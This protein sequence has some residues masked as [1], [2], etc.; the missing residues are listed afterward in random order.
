V[1]LKL[2]GSTSGSVELDV[3]AVVGGDVSLELP[4]GGTVD[5]LERAGNILQ[6]VSASTSTPVVNATNAYVDT[7]L[8]ATIT[9]TSASSKVLVLITQQYYHTR[10]DNKQGIGIRI[11]RDATLIY[12]PI[13]NATGPL[14]DYLQLNNVS[15]TT[16]Y[17]SFNRIVLDSPNTTSAVTYKTQGRPYLITGSAAFQASN[18]VN[19][20]SIINL[21]E[22][23]A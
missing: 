1:P 2:K 8:T 12:D 6:V 18:V 16:H 9:P 20:T 4:G 23:A 17:A 21:I 10:V 15:S 7:G 13:S 22:V 19:G 5:R 14:E 3:P 11:Y